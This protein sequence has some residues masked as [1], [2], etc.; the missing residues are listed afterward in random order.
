MKEIIKYLQENVKL[1]TAQ[2]KKEVVS[3]K[4]AI[5]FL[6]TFSIFIDVAFLIP[7]FFYLFDAIL[8]KEYY[9][10]KFINFFNITMFVT[11]WLLIIYGLFKLSCISK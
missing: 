2:F 7:L 6:T 8:D 9:N 1:N 3:N 5:L 10:K 11:F 4:I